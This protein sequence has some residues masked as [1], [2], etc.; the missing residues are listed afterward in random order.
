MRRFLSLIY[1][2]TLAL[3]ALGQIKAI[4]TLGVM[5]LSGTGI[6]AE[7]SRI[8]TE[9][10]LTG[11]VNA[12]AFDVVERSKRDEIL[13]EQGFQQTGACDEASCLVEIGKYLA[14]Q[15]MVG[16][17]VGKFG[18]TWTV[19]IRLL[20]VQTGRVER[21][22]SKTYK[23]EMDVLL[24][25]MQQA[26]AE[27]SGKS[28]SPDLAPENQLPK[29]ATSLDYYSRG[30]ELRQ[31]GK[32]P[33]A[34]RYFDEAIRLDPGLARY[35][36][37]R[38]F[39]HLEN[40]DFESARSDF[41]RAAIIEP[42]YVWSYIGLGD[43]FYQKQEYQQAL[44]PYRKAL[45][46]GGAK[47]E[48]QTRLHNVYRGLGDYD[49]ALAVVE[50]VL[51]EQKK[52]HNA[53]YLSGLDYYDKG[54]YRQ[55]LANFDKAIALKPGEAVYYFQ[56]GLA[57]YQLKSYPAAD[58][59]FSRAL[60][61]KPDYFWARAWRSAVRTKLKNYDAALA[62][63]DA[64]VALKPDEPELYSFRG[65]AYLEMKQYQRAVEDFARAIE[66]T[67]QKVNYYYQRANAYSLMD[68][69]F[70]AAADYDRAVFLQPDSAQP[71]HQR[72]S[73]LLLWAEYERAAKEETRALE[74]KPDYPEALSNR[75][76]A[77][78]LMG[79]N[80][81]AVADCDRVIR[82][83]EK[84][85]KAVYF[86]ALGLK[87]FCLGNYA[88]AVDHHSKAVALDP[89]WAGVI[90]RRGDVYSRMGKKD[91]AMADWR[92]ANE[93]N[94]FYPFSTEARR[95]IGAPLLSKKR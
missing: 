37:H 31:A 26:A 51:K 53:W 9:T 52:N 11:L 48:V 95:A 1:I 78:S 42:D 8:L 17:S 81:K 40:K 15:K 86:A 25:A 49:R 58:E 13:R 89:L 74:I 54:D 38:G 70:R 12:G 5:D 34:I 84:D 79:E 7:E 60:I 28:I 93:M 45:E 43:A 62:D 10:L 56:R 73:F 44:E 29:L 68:D 18:G 30:L 39:A 71:Y 6:S 72:G 3:V 50:Q 88:Q 59:D 85:K 21:A 77:F 94:R 23:G 64:A 82:L 61:L 22:V 63:I 2:L 90:S 27:L 32:L 35:Y 36:I 92:K 87:Q 83:T 20:D 65:Q 41:Q 16:G 67:P 76:L 4:T 66:L 80:D 24:T 46:L 47:A 14:V 57:H 55:A 33:E 19:N 91:L 69:Y 75:A